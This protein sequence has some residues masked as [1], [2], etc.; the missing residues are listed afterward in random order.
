MSHFTTK[1]Y[2]D[3]YAEIEFVKTPRMCYNLY[4][5]SIKKHMLIYNTM[6]QK[7]ENPDRH[8]SQRVTHIKTDNPYCA[9]KTQ[10]SDYPSNNVWSCRLHQ[11]YT[12]KRNTWRKRLLCSNSTC[13]K[14]S[15]I[16]M[17]RARNNVLIKV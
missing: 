7:S 9:Q 6:Y 14:N 12:G 8:G 11:L 2:V 13:Y 4:L 15:V 17:N 1:N 10:T 3:Q 5:H 16:C